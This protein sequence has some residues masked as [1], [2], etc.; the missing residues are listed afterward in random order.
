MNLERL[1]FLREE[2]D[3][4]QQD[5]A[6]ILGVSRVAVSQWETTK[7][8]IPLDKLNIYANH[9]Q[10]SMDYIIGLSNVKNSNIIKNDLSFND[11]G[12]RLRAI[13]RKFKLTQI[14]LA[15]YLNTSHSTIS[16]YETGKTLILTTFA[17]QICLKYHI[18]LDWLCGKT[19]KVGIL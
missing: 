14:N 9:F 5:M 7:E 13:R 11:I 19:K 18:S 2:N 17:Y 12:K 1:Y 10:V 16:A 4:T 8:I 15:Q 3:L 6:I